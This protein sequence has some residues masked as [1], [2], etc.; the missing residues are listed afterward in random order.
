MIN[1]LLLFVCKD[2]QCHL[3]SGLCDRNSWRGRNLFLHGKHFREY[4]NAMIIAMAMNLHLS[5]R[6]AFRSHPSLS[7]SLRQLSLSYSLLEKSPIDLPKKPPTPWIN[8]YS[9]NYQP[10]KKS[11]PD[12]TTPELMRKISQ[13]W[14]K[15]PSEEK[16]KLQALYHKQKEVYAT[17]LAEVPQDQIDEAKAV[18]KAKQ[19]EKQDK[20]IEKQAKL[21]EK[22]TLKDKK[23]AESE[24]KNLLTSLK[25][26]KRPVSSY[27]LYC[28]DRRPKLPDSLSATEKVKQMAEE[29]R[30]SDRKT[31]ERYEKK[32]KELVEM[33]EEELDS[34]SMR[35]H[36]EGK[37]EDIARAQTKVMQLRKSAKD[38]E[39]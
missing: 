21:N 27:I 1:Y 30:E 13:D 14:A 36:K 37:T 33:Y 34:W 23:S 2:D 26:P 16:S 25:K 6:Q 19:M 4:L 11:F 20:E 35:M 10:Y 28:M 22:Q 29:W 24:L 5:A 8:Y 9:Q 12:L 38:Q 15:V 3:N 32:N 18:K 17:K 31:R 7:S 39:Y